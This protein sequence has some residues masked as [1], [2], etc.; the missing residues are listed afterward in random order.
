MPSPQRPHRSA[1]ARYQ[2]HC[3][4]LILITAGASSEQTLLAAAATSLG[5][6]LDDVPHNGKCQF[7]SILRQLHAL[8]EPRA[9]GENADS[10]RSTLL[11]LI[12]DPA[13]LEQPWSDTTHSGRLRQHIQ[14]SATQ[15]TPP[16]SVAAW[17]TYMSKPTA[18]G[19]D[20]TLLLTAIKYRVRIVVLSATSTLGHHEIAVPLSYAQQPTA[21]IYLGQLGE[22]HYLSL[23]H[24]PLR[25]A[26]CGQSNIMLRNCS[27][28]AQ[29]FCFKCVPRL[30]E[31]CARAGI[32]NSNIDNNDNLCANNSDSG[33]VTQSFT[34]DSEGDGDDQDEAQSA[35]DARVAELLS[36]QADEGIF[37]NWI[38][39]RYKEVIR[40]FAATVMRGA[41]RNELTQV[42]T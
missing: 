6:Q 24:V 4:H 26:Q 19:D 23:P 16:L 10:L 34:S 21:T 20:I 30:T 38:K 18:W 39:E 12:D 5:R 33:S 35:A 8:S 9:V 29:L 31:H 13:F 25:C 37:P 32:A 14:A 1:G 40:P 11:A 3:T 36:L 22:Y 28:C 7:T 17:R 2:C 41:L 42:C 27:N 15:Y